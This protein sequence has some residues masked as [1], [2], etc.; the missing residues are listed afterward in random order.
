MVKK[1]NKLVG[2]C[3]IYRWDKI[4][5]SAELRSF[6]DPDYSGRGFGTEQHAFVLKMGFGRYNL[7]RVYCGTHEENAAILRIYEK[8]HLTKEGILRQDT[9]RNG[10]YSDT[11]RYSILR[12]EYDSEVKKIVDSFLDI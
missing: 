8:L 12:N 2:W 3:G 4:S 10:K 7:N 6:V 1:S 9:I 11:V 5:H